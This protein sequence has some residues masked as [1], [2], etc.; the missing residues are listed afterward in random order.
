MVSRSRIEEITAD[1]AKRH[2]LPETFDELDALSR[3]QIER[4]AAL[5]GATPEIHYAT[6]RVNREATVRS[7]D[8][9][10]EMLAEIRRR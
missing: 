4:E 7:N 6:V 3:R 2:P 8:R 10:D 9:V 5:I 1:V